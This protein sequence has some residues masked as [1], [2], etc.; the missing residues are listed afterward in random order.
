MNDVRITF[1]IMQKGLMFKNFLILSLSL[2]FLCLSV[3]LSISKKEQ[4]CGCIKCYTGTERECRKK[5][6]S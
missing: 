6:D 1:Y 2:V 5:R 4:S 3:Y